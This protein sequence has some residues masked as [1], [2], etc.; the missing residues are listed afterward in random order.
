VTLEGRG[1]GQRGIVF[2]EMTAADGGGAGS[3]RDL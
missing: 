3:L 1:G 2:V